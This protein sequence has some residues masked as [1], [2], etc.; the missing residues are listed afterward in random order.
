MITLTGLTRWSLTL[1]ILIVAGC[2]G[3][4][5]NVS[6]YSLSSLYVGHQAVAPVSDGPAIGI[7]AI[8]L[9]D[10]LDRPQ[11]VTRTAPNRMQIAEYHRWAGQ[12]KDEISRVLL[13]NLMSLTGS[14]QIVRLPWP[15]GFNPD[16]SVTVEIT[17]FEAYADSKVRLIGS[18]T[19]G[20][21]PRAIPPRILHVNLE[22][23][24][25]SDAYADLVAAQSRA[26]ITLSSQINAALA[27][28]R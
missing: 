22:E 2:A 28:S 19:L 13:E 21:G 8:D 26:L 14:R 23:P 12:L 4:S 16:L 27:H 3:G 6:F 7:G 1:C 5:S 9:P 20:G 10:Y 15:P 11:I 18:V 25:P 17:T 24:A